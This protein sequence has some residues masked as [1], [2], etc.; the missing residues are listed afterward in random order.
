MAEPSAV[1]NFSSGMR[2]QFVQAASGFLPS[3]ETAE[4][5]L[6]GLPQSALQA[7][8]GFESFCQRVLWPLLHDQPLSLPLEEESLAAY[9]TANELLA[10]VVA[11]RHG[12]EPIWIH[13]FELFALP[14]LVRKHL[15]HSRV[16]W[17]LD[18][19]FPSAELFRTL[20]ARERLLR[21]ALGADLIGFQTSQ[22]LRHF[23]SS[24]ELLLGQAAQLDRVRWQ[25]RWVRLGVFP[26]GVDVPGLLEAADSQ[27]VRARVEQLRS[28]P[29]KLVGGVDRPGANSGIY[30]KLLAFE[31]LLEQHPELEGQLRLHQACLAPHG[32]WSERETRLAARLCERFGDSRWQPVLLEKG[33]ALL[34]DRVA[35]YLASDVYWVSC[36]RD[37]MSLTAKEFLAARKDEKGVLVLSELSG[38]A[39]EL[40]E[41]LQVNPYDLPRMALQLH[42]A[43]EL[44]RLEALGR[45][46]AL[47]RR[48]LSRDLQAW[49][50]SFLEELSLAEPD[51]AELA[52]TPWASLDQALVLL[53]AAP[54]LLLLLDYDGTLVPFA[55]LPDLAAPD[56]A[57]LSLLG[58]LADRPNTEVHV[59][60]GRTK[61]TLEE[62][63]GHLP[64]GLHAEHGF[65]TRLPGQK[66]WQASPG[67]AQAWRSPA[68]EILRDFQARTPGSLIEEKDAGLA[69]H[70]RLASAEVGP[71]RARELEIHLRD[72]FAA[73]PV[74]VL[75]GDKVVELRPKGIDKGAV[76]LP[77]LQAAGEGTAIVALGDDVTDED[78]FGALPPQAV[79]LHVGPKPS[80][81]ALRLEDV[82]EARSFLQKL[83][84][85]SL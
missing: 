18:A 24:V 25:R 54:R 33:P 79:A 48:V 45:M 34:E 76:V 62:W 15:P 57:L 78:L 43:L 71:R 4:T 65:W 17:F 16:G 5:T 8:R 3:V 20:P 9:L 37:G 50:R 49:T 6:E 26:M 7:A 51:A 30:G 77:L 36:L 66:H 19:P 68:L 2:V 44:P 22:H 52:P 32:P 38:A 81:A 12:N 21:G 72:T 55:S 70:Y 31:L 10:Q 83:L 56:Q 74:Q 23:C 29:G 53:R 35:L 28:A 47:R 27:E 46:R 75:P 61:E 85:P 58:A 1:A 73:L 84:V 80:R 39:P 60:S 42:R 63:L 14:E 41:A 69:W 11:E 82:Q 13:G 59:V 64:L 40:P 67:G